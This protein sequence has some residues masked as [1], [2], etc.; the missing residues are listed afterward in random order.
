MNPEKFQETSPLLPEKN[1]IEVAEAGEQQ[2]ENDNYGLLDPVEYRNRMLSEIVENRELDLSGND[3]TIVAEYLKKQDPGYM[4][5][6]RS[7]TIGEKDM[8]K[9]VEAIIAIPSYREGGN[10]E[11][12]LRN[13]AKLKS[14]NH[15]EIDILENHPEGVER[16]NSLEVIESIKREFPDL[17]IVHLYKVFKEKPT[18]GQVRKYLVDAVLLRKMEGDIE[19]SLAIISNDADLEDISEDYV[20]RISAVFKKNKGLDAIEG[21]WDYPAETFKNFPLLHATQRLWRYLDIAFR[22]YGLKTQDLT[23]TNSV[24]RSGIY[25]AVGGYN[26]EALLAE[27]WEIGQ[28]IKAARGNNQSVGRVDSAWLISNPRRAVAKMLSGNRFIEQH[29]D[30]HENEDVRNASLEDLFPEKREFNEEE[31]AKEVQA[32]Y[33]HCEGWKKSNGG[34]IDDKYINRSFDRAMRFLG[35]SYNI[36]DDEI[37]ILNTERLKK[38]LK[39]YELR[40]E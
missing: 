2:S 3:L 10:L 8:S 22:N 33:K 17:D 31:F 15:F 9:D 34:S 5:E 40:G 29:E 16:D 7:M 11:K 30:F 1:I 24:F 12:T 19:K 26:Q 4:A 36:Q 28:L 21:R 18:I 39:D 35:V 14:R 23:G 6:I 32:I 38:G 37:K 27:D 13:Y 25:A 20:D